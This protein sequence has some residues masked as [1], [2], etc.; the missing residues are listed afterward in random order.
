MCERQADLE[1]TVEEMLIKEDDLIDEL[2]VLTMQFEDD[3]K[4]LRGILQ[5]KED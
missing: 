4:R 3:E 1:A 5:K 2:R